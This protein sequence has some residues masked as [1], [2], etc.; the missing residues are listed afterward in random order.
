MNNFI[1]T[2]LRLMNKKSPGATI[3]FYM[4]TL[5]SLFIVNRLG[6]T[7][8]ENAWLNVLSFVIVAPPLFVFFFSFSNLIKYETLKRIFR[9]AAT[10]AVI[11][12]GVYFLVCA[13]VAFF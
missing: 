10:G 2:V 4:I 5:A 13:L 7:A 9:F 3:L 12:C 6:I 11:I 8:R 1:Y